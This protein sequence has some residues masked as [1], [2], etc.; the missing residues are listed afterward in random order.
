[1][2]CAINCKIGLERMFVGQVNFA[3]CN[4]VIM[5]YG[6]YG[7]LIQRKLDV[8]VLMGGRGAGASGSSDLGRFEEGVM[9]G[10]RPSSVGLILRASL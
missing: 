7:G 8:I 4:R 10:K 9:G 5:S 3:N 6:S 2:E 1:M